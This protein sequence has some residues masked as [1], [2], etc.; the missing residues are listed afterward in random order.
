MIVM[1][2]SFV[3]H[4]HHFSI[5]FQSMDQGGFVGGF[6]R[7][8][9]DHRLCIAQWGH[10][11]MQRWGRGEAWMGAGLFLGHHLIIYHHLSMSMPLF[12]W[13]YLYCMYMLIYIYMCVCTYVWYDMCNIWNHAGQAD[14][15]LN[16]WRT[17]FYFFFCETLSCWRI[18]VFGKKSANDSEYVFEFWAQYIKIMSHD[19]H[20]GHGHSWK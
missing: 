14:I 8:G 20:I 9:A 17:T 5:T 1:Y 4:G 19:Y 16:F 12:P 7:P 18:P 13:D 10:P 3:L 6:A 11:A 2:Q 15:R